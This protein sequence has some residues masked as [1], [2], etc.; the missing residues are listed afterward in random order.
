MAVLTEQR[1]CLS[2]RLQHFEP[3]D[4]SAVAWAFATVNHDDGPLMA[5]LGARVVQTLSQTAHAANSARGST[6][7]ADAAAAEPDDI[8]L[9]PAG[10]T[11]E[12][13]ADVAWAC[14]VQRKYSGQL[15]D[16]LTSSA[17][18]RLREFQ[19]APLAT[20]LWAFAA[21]RHLDAA[22]LDQAAAQIGSQ[23]SATVAAAAGSGS[24]GS[25]A[26]LPAP[27]PATAM[28]LSDAAVAAEPQG[29]LT[30]QLASVVARDCTWAPVQ[31]V[32]AAWAL[33]QFPGALLRHRDLISRLLAVA[34]VGAEQLTPGELADACWAAAVA[35][36]VGSAAGSGTGAADGSA[37][38]AANSAATGAAPVSANNALGTDGLAT[39]LAGTLRHLSV[40]LRTWKA[41]DFEPHDLARLLEADLFV[42]CCA[43]GAVEQTPL[44]AMPPACS[45]GAAATSSSDA[46]HTGSSGA[47]ALPAALRQA[48]RRAQRS[49]LRAALGSAFCREV[50]ATAADLP[51]WT[52]LLQD[53]DTGSDPVA[54]AAAA[55]RLAASSGAEPL[56]RDA[57][58]GASRSA[59]GGDSTGQQQ[60]PLAKDLLVW[61]QQ[62]LV[63]QSAGGGALAVLLPAPAAQLARGASAG[64]PNQLLTHARLRLNLYRRAGVPAIAVSQAEWA[65]LGS[66]GIEKANVLLSKLSLLR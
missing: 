10:Y 9:S 38:G 17:K 30:P 16:G 11:P 64:S 42:S 28:A 26:A 24:A 61:F 46:A 43:T 39:D 35:I 13:V 7:P 47:L 29:L 21:S 44:R 33:S 66:Q 18:Q 56:S 65:Q 3:R 31:A 5:A 40:A 37:T 59:A 60:G 36:A 58:G 50:R 2:P 54:L 6:R 4:V 51:G 15:F 48:A 32:Q 19:P 1:F 63:L 8:G 14:A 55:A 62:D 27:A 57:A 53:G 25:G 45:S 41:G 22:L 20:L 12:Q 49:A 23:L 34:A 52:L